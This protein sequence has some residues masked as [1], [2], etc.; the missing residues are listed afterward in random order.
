MDLCECARTIEKKS[1]E[2]KTELADELEIE[3]GGRL[4]LTENRKIAKY[5]KT[6]PIRRCLFSSRWSTSGASLLALH[7][8]V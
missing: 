4:Y 7:L 2:I 5:K 1:C 6:F 3:L 8:C